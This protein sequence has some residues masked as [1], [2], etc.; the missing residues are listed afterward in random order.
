[1]VKGRLNEE[2]K[3]T[4]LRGCFALTSITLPDSVQSIGEA[5]FLGCYDLPSII[6]P[7]SLQSIGT[8]AFTYCYNMQRFD[9]SKIPLETTKSIN[10]IGNSESV[11]C[12]DGG[13]AHIGKIICR[14]EQ[15]K[16]MRAAFKYTGIEF[17]D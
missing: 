17:V 15:A 5:A 16:T 9:I 8:A 10:W 12:N 11:F 1:M 7:A 6:L 2:V 13:Y 4:F 14:K 3:R